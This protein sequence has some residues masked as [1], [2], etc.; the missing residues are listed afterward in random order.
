MPRIIDSPRGGPG[1]A[2]RPTAGDESE[3]QQAW[4]LTLKNAATRSAQV[5][6]THPA[7]QFGTSHAEDHRQPPRR[8]GR[9]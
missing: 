6:P 1:A 9:R 4:S 3:L 8:T 5:Q 2:R 7:S